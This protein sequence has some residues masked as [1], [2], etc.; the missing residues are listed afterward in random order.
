MNFEL[1]EQTELFRDSVRKWVNAECPKAWCRELERAEHQYPQELW[2]KLVAGGYQ[3]IGIPEE[4]G[5]L[6]GD[7]LIQAI[8]MREFARNAAG[9][10]WIW[11]VTAFSGANALGLAASEEQKRR[12]LPAMAAGKLRTAI[13]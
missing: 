2:N 3:G 6:G 4:Y 8:F 1:D 11:G 10:G 5:G 9:L 7:M 12:F 13:S